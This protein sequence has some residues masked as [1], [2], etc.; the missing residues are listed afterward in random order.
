M[1]S[2]GQGSLRGNAQGD[3]ASKAAGGRLF[4]KARTCMTK[5]GL[6]MRF[7]KGWMMWRLVLELCHIYDLAAPELTL[8]GGRFAPTSRHG[9]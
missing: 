5:V 7:S 4:G 6:W 9:R 2:G 1:Q 8:R 3:A